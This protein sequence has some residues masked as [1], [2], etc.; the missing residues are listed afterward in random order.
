MDCKTFFCSFIGNR[1]TAEECSRNVILFKTNFDRRLI[2][3]FFRSNTAQ[4]AVT[5]LNWSC[6]LYSI[7]SKKKED[8]IKLEMK[9]IVEA[10]AFLLTAIVS[11]D[12]SKLLDKAYSL[13]FK[14]ASF[15]L[16]EIRKWKYFS[17]E[18][19]LGSS[20]K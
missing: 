3:F 14:F 6:L 11:A 7:G 15:L 10:Q 8:A 19:Y 5:A 9:K 16:R 12:N 2:V 13:V 17:A 18:W 20:E 4:T 1:A